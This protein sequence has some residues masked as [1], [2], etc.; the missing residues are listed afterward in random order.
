MLCD[1]DVQ[2]FSQIKRNYSGKVVSIFIKTPTLKI[3]EERLIARGTN[4]IKQIKE[5]LNS[6]E[7]ELKQQ[8][9]YDYIVINDD[10][11]NAKSEIEEIF[12]K[13]L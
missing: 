1:I 7:N 12:R 2:G 6:A 4:T 3:A 9:K 13:N 5:R 10:L 8:D 11:E